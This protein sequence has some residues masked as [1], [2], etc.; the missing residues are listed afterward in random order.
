MPAPLLQQA[1]A[2]P[3]GPADRPLAEGMEAWGHMPNECLAL[4]QKSRP[5][6]VTTALGAA[7]PPGPPK[8]GPSKGLG[9]TA[10]PRQQLHFQDEDYEDAPSPRV[11]RA[12]LT[13]ATSI[14]AP[15]QR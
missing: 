4:A 14:N 10:P 13:C 12:H 11:P 9:L 7:I 1:A 2:A 6:P 15:L 8:P 3:P 5:L